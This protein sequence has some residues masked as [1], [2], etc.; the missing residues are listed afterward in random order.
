MIL[1]LLVAYVAVKAIGIHAVA[2]VF[3]STRYQA[4]RRVTLFAQGGEGEAVAVVGPGTPP[5]RRPPVTRLPL[6]LASATPA[7]RE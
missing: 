4:L 3:G 7:F 6:V 2:R 5:D 1:A